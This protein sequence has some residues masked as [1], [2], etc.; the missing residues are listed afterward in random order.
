MYQEKPIECEKTNKKG[1]VSFVYVTVSYVLVLT[2][3]FEHMLQLGTGRA[4]RC[5]YTWPEAVR[6]R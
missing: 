3:F 4:E 2:I 1:A 5:I 6:C